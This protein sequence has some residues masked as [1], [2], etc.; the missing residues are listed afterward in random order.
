MYLSSS[1]AFARAVKT[2]F[3]DYLRLSIHHSTGEHKLSVSLLPT[4]T[5]FTTPWHCSVGFKTDGT[6]VSRPKGEFEDDPIWKLVY[7]NGRP[8]HFKEIDIAAGEEIEF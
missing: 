3:P 7:E 1:Q 6:L 4:Q 8:S 2:N 5:S